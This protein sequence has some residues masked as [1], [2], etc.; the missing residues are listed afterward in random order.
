M[1]G[2]VNIRPAAASDFA[3]AQSLLS[4]AG[5]PSADLTTAHMSGFLI[6][7]KGGDPIGMVG[8]ERTGNF[9]LVRS[10]VVDPSMRSVGVGGRLVNDMEAR[11]KSHGVIELWLLTI[12]ADG[13]FSKLHYARRERSEA[14]VEIQDTKEFS[15]L[16]P[17][18]AVLMSKLL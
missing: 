12:D 13:Y 8:I 14:P 6:A 10:L 9:G 2:R 4:A 16:C 3:T 11:A 5:L 1:G 7:V 18:D 15:S 17:G